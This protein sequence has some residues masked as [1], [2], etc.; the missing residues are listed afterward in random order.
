MG[1]R[2]EELARA[3]AS[4]KN[5]QGA[6]IDLVIVG[7]GWN[8]AIQFPHEKTL[9][10]PENLGI[11]AGRNAGVAQVSGEYLFFLDD[12]AYLDNQRSLKN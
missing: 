3:L 8:P 10:L 11:P 9:H 1:K 7:N 12:D 6:T 2:P 5:Q 4:L